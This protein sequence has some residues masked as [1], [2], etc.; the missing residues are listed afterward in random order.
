MKRN[1]RGI[2]LK[3]EM[4]ILSLW[5]LFFMII[6]SSM[7]DCVFR[8]HHSGWR[9]FCVEF[10]KYDWL[11]VVCVCLLGLCGVCF[12]HFRTHTIGSMQLAVKVKGIE[13]R[14]ADF[15]L[16][17]S[18]Y[19]IPLVTMDFTSM[20]HLIILLVLLIAIGCMYVKTDLFLANPTLALLGYKVYKVELDAIQ[21]NGV[22]ITMDQLE[23]DDNVMFVRLSQGA[24]F[25]KKV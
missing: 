1:Y 9:A 16:L 8:H 13:N 6:I 22:A 19:I 25:V 2:F 3:V 15:L 18:T 12:W 23:D 14:N 4:Y 20:R 7:N 11:V 17:L 5:L 21:G 10:F 24:F